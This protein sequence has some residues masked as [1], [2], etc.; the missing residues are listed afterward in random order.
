MFIFLFFMALAIVTHVNNRVKDI[1]QD[2]ND[3]FIF[4]GSSRWIILGFIGLSILLQ[5]LFKLPFMRPHILPGIAVSFFVY[6]TGMYLANDI[7]VKLIEKKRNQLLE[8]Y[9]VI[10]RLLVAPGQRVPEELDFNNIPFEP[11]YHRGDLV[12]LKIDILNSDIFTDKAL[13]DITNSMN[14][15]YPKKKWAYKIDFPN[16]ECILEGKNHP[17]TK[18]P[19]PGSDFR[20]WNWIPVGMSAEGELGWNLGVKKKF[21]GHSS[22]FFEDEDGNKTR[23]QTIDIPKAPQGLTLGS[24]GGGKAIFIEQHVQIVKD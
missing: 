14:K 7:R 6:I 18:A 2:N 8:I 12:G 15:Y 10:K 11:K 21:I 19:Y 3:A 23:A 5:F 16:L 22:F 9:G 24:T 20:P 4:D 17:P 13:T 1:D